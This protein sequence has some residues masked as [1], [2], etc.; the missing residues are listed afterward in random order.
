M[1]GP[2]AGRVSDRGTDETCDEGCMKRT[3]AQG[4]SVEVANRPRELANPWLAG[5]YSVRMSHDDLQL[6]ST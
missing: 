2:K 3:R 5:E 1:D 6:P 4:G